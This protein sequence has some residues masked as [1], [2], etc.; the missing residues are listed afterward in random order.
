MEN[1]EN[2]EIIIRFT[3]RAIP[4]MNWIIF[5]TIPNIIMNPIF[6]I[7]ISILQILYIF[8]ILFFYILALYFL[9]SAKIQITRSGHSEHIKSPVGPFRTWIKS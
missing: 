4:N 6:F 7:I 3:E 2:M 1:M 5:Y 9:Y 8:H